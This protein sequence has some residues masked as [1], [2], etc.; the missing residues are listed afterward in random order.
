M[1]TDN[2]IDIIVASLVGDDDFVAAMLDEPDTWETNYRDMIASMLGEEAAALD[3]EDLLEIKESVEDVIT[4]D[5]M[6]DDAAY[7]D[8]A[9][10]DEADRIAD[11]NA[12]GFDQH[13][14]DMMHAAQEVA[15]AIASGNEGSATVKV[16][17]ND[18]DSAPDK[19]TVEENKD[20]GNSDLQEMNDEAGDMSNDAKNSVNSIA[21]HLSEYRW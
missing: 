21:R 4:A 2:D 10:L 6:A 14:K 19:V 1:I 9:I 3:E 11:E 20:A 13:T 12:T 16:E 17:E 5:A 18:S 7:G 15:K 8:Q